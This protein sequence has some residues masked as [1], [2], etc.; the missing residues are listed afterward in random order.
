M[1]S[2]GNKGQARPKEGGGAE[3]RRIDKSKLEDLTED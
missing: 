3:G 2:T 1:K